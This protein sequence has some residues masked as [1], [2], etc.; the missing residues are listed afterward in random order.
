MIVILAFS[1]ID[2]SFVGSAAIVASRLS[3]KRLLNNSSIF[4]AEAGGILLAL[5]VYFVGGQIS[6]NDDDDWT[7]VNSQLAPV[8]Y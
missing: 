2:L 1:L 6:L 3:K 5:P 8:P 7:S 4:S